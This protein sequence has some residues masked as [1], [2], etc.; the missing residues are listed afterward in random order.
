MFVHCIFLQEKVKE[1]A[2]Y[3]REGLSAALLSKKECCVTVYPV[4][5]FFK[6]K[7]AIQ[8]NDKT[9]YHND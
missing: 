1:E 8:L 6:A 5:N 3:L 4:I 9:A 2:R 7:R